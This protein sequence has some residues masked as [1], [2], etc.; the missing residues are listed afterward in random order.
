MLTIVAT[1]IGHLED[2][3]PRMI[4]MLREADHLYAEDTRHTAKLLN[5]FQIQRGLD[6]FHEHSPPQ[7]LA[8]IG[9]KLQRGEHVVYVSD[10]GT[11][12]ISDPGY[13]L[14]TLA[15]ELDV[16]VDAVPGP[17]SVINALVLS[18]L[19]S[20]AFC[21]LGFFPTKV[22]KRRELATKLAQMNMT[23]IFFESPKR[24]QSSL[25]FLAEA[26]P[27][28]KMALCRE[29]TKR[30]Q[31]VLRGRA[32]QI[33][34][35]LQTIK[36]ECVLVI[37]PVAHHIEADSLPEEDRR[38][39]ASGLSLSQRAKTLAKQFGLPK[40]QVYQQI[41]GSDQDEPQDPTTEPSPS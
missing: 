12:A 37:A 15:H 31:Q 24:V 9:E 21:F 1:P 18:G 26:S 6:S 35:Q 13:E 5:H 17:C 40:R 20:H 7:I 28:T 36:G 14:V 41:R 33:L 38:L 25:A 4:R 27:Q 11:P 16:P 10:A 29:M 8:R 2:S 34:A 19:P 32:E 39:R 22:Q 3:S 30:H 23:S